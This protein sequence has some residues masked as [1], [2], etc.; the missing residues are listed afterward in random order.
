[1][2]VGAEHSQLL[3]VVAGRNATDASAW[4]LSGVRM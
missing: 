4:W 3:D 1:V 2:D